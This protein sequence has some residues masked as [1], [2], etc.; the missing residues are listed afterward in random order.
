MEFA[1]AESN[2]KE[3]VSEY[4][5]YQDAS[6]DEDNGEEEDAAAAPA[7]EGSDSVMETGQ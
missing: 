4:E 6:I 1:E 2:L 3:L 5:Q 7:P